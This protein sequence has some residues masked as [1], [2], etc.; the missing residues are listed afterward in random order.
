L[1]LS[2]AIAGSA[3]A[4]GEAPLPA[5]FVATLKSHTEAIYTVGFS[6]DGRCVLTGSFDKTLKL[7]DATTG[8]EVI[9]LGGP[10]GHQ[11]LV[12]SAAF[13]PDGRSIA[14]GGSD[15]TAKLWENPVLDRLRPITRFGKAFVFPVSFGNN[16]LLVKPGTAA[17]MK[18]LAH[19]NLVD[20]VAFDPAGKQLA[21]GSHDGTVR[22]WDVSKGQQLREIKAHTTPAMSPVYC[23][24]WTPDGKHVLSGSLDRMMKLWDAKSGTMVREFKPYK[25]KDFEKGHRDGVFSVAI[26]PDGK[27]IAS[28]SSDRSIKLWSLADGS[29]VRDF[30]LPGV[31]STGTPGSHSVL[32]YAVAHP[33]WV[34]SLRFTGDGK[35]LVS[36]GAAPRNHGFLAIWDA[37]DGKLLHGQDLPLGPFYS[38]AVSPDGKLIALACGPR[39][40]KSPEAYGYILKMP[41]PDGKLVSQAEK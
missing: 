7:W 17:P 8:K 10:Q 14:S 35:Y 18:N 21:T 32:S 28:G 16:V 25:E 6:P 5:G 39:D 37:A 1:A 11:Q 12:L 15:N 41:A 23:V 36:A 24:A 22:I 31:G 3:F 4:S 20:A 34:Y 2:G 9:T 33:G 40:R 29:V 30:A 38:V 26:S 27:R 13:S 19:A